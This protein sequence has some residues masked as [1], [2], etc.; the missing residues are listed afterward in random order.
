[1][2]VF[3]FL[4]NLF[5][6]IAVVALVADATPTGS[7]AHGFSASSLTNH[8]SELAPTSLEGAKAGISRVTYPWVWDSVIANVLAVP[9]FVMFGF[10]ALMSG[11][12]GRRRKRVDLYV[13]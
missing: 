10:L 6:L 13:N 11:Y 12:I 5:L 2:A 7:E 1:M 4:A 3:R 9:T 8:W